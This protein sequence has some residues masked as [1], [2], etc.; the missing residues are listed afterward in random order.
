M[1]PRDLDSLLQL[2]LGTGHGLTSLP[3]DRE[4]LKERLIDGEKSF[5][6][7]K[8]GKP[9]GEDYLFALEKTDTDDIIG[10][11]GIW[12]KIGGFEPV[13]FYEIKEELRKSDQIGVE[14][15]IKTLHL[16][17]THDGPSEVC[18]LYLHPKYRKSSTGRLLSLSRFLFIADHQEYFDDEVIAE[19]RGMVDE[20]G[21]NPFW[22]A[23][24]AKFFK[25]D[26]TYA[27]YMSMKSKKWI[28][29]LQPDTPIIVNLLPES[30]QKVIS[31]V[32]PN[33]VAAKKI[34]EKEGFHD[35]GLVAILE[36]GPILIAKVKDIRTIQKSIVSKVLKTSNHSDSEEYL[37]SNR[38]F[39]DFHC[40]LG[41]VELVDGGVHLSEQVMKALKVEKG[42]EVRFVRLK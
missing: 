11:S 9:S 1:K 42:N 29:E 26:F 23:V 27:D 25:I 5:K 8:P 2:V 35:S 15:K 40:C 6:Y 10:V 7:A 41:H 20:D 39:T 3:K 33:T 37:I 14:T 22:N 12:S 18:S 36:P 4:I 34:L 32:H 24:G 13:Y 38:K 21:Q 30:A 16:R 31:Q 19:M 17:P 28:K